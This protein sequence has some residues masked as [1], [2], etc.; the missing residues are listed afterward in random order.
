MRYLSKK[1]PQA[2]GRMGPTEVAANTIHR[3]HHQSILKPGTREHLHQHPFGQTLRLCCVVRSATL[4]SCPLPRR[5]APK[6]CI[7]VGVLLHGASTPG[8][9]FQCR[10]RDTSSRPKVLRRRPQTRPSSAAKPTARATEQATRP[11]GS[12]TRLL[13]GGMSKL[14]H[15]SGCTTYEL[16]IPQFHSSA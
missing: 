11:G 7:S 14:S 6:L 1:C 4:E 8:C 2:D 13:P 10:P 9:I 5:S 12:V 3:H 15:L 16:R